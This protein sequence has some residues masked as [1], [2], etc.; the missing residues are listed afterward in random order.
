LLPDEYIGYQP[1]LQE[2]RTYTKKYKNSKD[3]I[4][5]RWKTQPAFTNVFNIEKLL[6]IMTSIRQISSS[7][8]LEKIIIQI[9][10]DITPT[11]KK[12]ET[13]TNN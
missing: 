10:R 8:A 13:K 2:Q 5:T 9:Q 3:Q 6:S 12:N 1:S 7:K 4:Y 11:E